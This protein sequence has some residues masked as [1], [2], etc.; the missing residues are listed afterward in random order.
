MWKIP[1]L[2]PEQSFLLSFRHAA[3]VESSS[4]RCFPAAFGSGPR[5]RCS[6]QSPTGLVKPP[7]SCQAGPQQL[8]E[9]P[10][11]S[12]EQ[13]LSFPAG[14][15]AGHGVT[16]ARWESGFVQLVWPCYGQVSSLTP[17][18]RIWQ[19]VL[20]RGAPLSPGR[21]AAPCRGHSSCSAGMLCVPGCAW[22]SWR[23]EQGREGA[24][25]VGYKAFPSQVCAW[26]A[27]ASQLTTALPGDPGDPPGDPPG[28][29]LAALL[30]VV[31][32][33]LLAE[34]VGGRKDLGWHMGLVIVIALH[35]R[36]SLALGE[37]SSSSSSSL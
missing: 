1:W 34:A 17:H 21:V 23:W 12:W 30:S 7:Q 15:S 28:S 4:S 33:D 10:S 14:P 2:H 3:K 31:S 22:R 36:M 16:G 18:S 29:P 35:C 32:S 8:P 6:S 9:L 19:L 20:P 25:P 26:A 13:N 24:P 11:S 5:Y 37:P 27:T